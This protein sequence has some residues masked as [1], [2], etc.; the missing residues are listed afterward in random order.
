MQLINSWPKSSLGNADFIPKCDE[1]PCGIQSLM[2]WWFMIITAAFL[3]CLIVRGYTFQTN[4][5][6]FHFPRR[7]CENHQLLII[8]NH[9]KCAGW[10]GVVVSEGAINRPSWIT[11]LLC[12]VFNCSKNYFL[13][14]LALQTSLCH[15]FPL[16]SSNCCVFCF[17][18]WRLRQQTGAHFHDSTSAESG[19]VKLLCCFC[20]VF[21]HRLWGSMRF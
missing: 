2:D 18:F 4:C 15:L 12:D 16:L 13:L 1:V 20:N 21:L 8:D 5:S 3:L 9:L 19:Q 17:R 6:V 11:S 7:Q 10:D 14:S